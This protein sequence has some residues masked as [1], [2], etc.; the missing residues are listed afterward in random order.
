MNETNLTQYFARN[1]LIQFA[2]EEAFWWKQAY[3]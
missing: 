2:Y 1:F 3:V